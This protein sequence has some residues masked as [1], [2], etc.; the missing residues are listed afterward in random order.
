MR[1]R[2]KKRL[3][4]IIP[5][6][7]DGRSFNEIGSIFG[8]SAQRARQLYHR[9]VRERDHNA[10]QWWYGLSFRA[11]K[12]LMNSG[13]DSREGARTAISETRLVP[14]KHPRNYG[15]KTHIEVLKWLGLVP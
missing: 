7:R 1:E 10:R 14:N 11:K 3:A 5:L 4:L 12:C 13:V 15:F 2:T 8:C 9:A 6:R